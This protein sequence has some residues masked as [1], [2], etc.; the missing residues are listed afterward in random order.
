MPQ[1]TCRA[2]GPSLGHGSD[3]PLRSTGA[4]HMNV[5]HVQFG[6]ILAD[7]QRTADSPMK[8]FR[9]STTGASR[10]WVDSNSSAT[11]IPFCQA[12]HRVCT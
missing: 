8:S 3:D 12:G 10:V 4:G 7:F 2:A 11:V 1:A 9:L 6:K 5:F